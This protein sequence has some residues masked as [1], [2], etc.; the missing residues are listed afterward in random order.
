MRRNSMILTLA[1]V[2]ACLPAAPAFAAKSHAV[3]LTLKETGIYETLGSDP[4][5]PVLVIEA[6]LFKGSL[7][8]GVNRTDVRLRDGKGTREFYNRHGSIHGSFVFTGERKSNGDTI[9]GTI[10]ITGGTG[11]YAH[12]HGKLHIDGFHNDTTGYSTEHITGSLKY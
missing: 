10:T 7:G 12:A 9:V 6:G 1:L 4:G 11:R 3:N 8:A 5:P 2:A